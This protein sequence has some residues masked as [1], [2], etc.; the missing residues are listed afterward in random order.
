MSGK[1][2]LAVAGVMGAAGVAIGAFGAHVLPAWLERSG[3]SAD[4]IPARIETFEI[5][6]RYH[7]Y[8][9]L[10]LLGVGLWARGTPR[11]GVTWAGVCFLLGIMIFSGFLYANAMTGIKVLGMIVPVGGVLLIV[12]WLILAGAAVTS[13]DDAG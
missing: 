5:G 1:T 4:Q 12:G 7:L 13:Q 2:W 11:H 6:V 9:A 10:A 8:H 3:V